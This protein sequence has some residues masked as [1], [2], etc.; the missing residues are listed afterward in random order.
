M[1]T[2]EYELVWQEPWMDEKHGDMDKNMLY[3]SQLEEKGIEISEEQLQ[4]LDYKEKPILDESG[5]RY[6]AMTWAVK[7]LTQQEFKVFINGFMLAN[8]DL[9][10]AKLMNV[11]LQRVR[12]IRAQIR[13]KLANYNC[14]KPKEEVYI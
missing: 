4:D 7:N 1:E 13:K 8:P 14:N 10:V 9:S 12:M 6:R 3:F 2:I 5:W 11:S